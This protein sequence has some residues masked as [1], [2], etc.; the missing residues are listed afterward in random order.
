[1]IVLL[2]EIRLNPTTKEK[3]PVVWQPWH[4]KEEMLACWHAGHFD[5][6]F[7]RSNFI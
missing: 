3:E 6:C 7:Y 2:P 1:M 4:E 5:V